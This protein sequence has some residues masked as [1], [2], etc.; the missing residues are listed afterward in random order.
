MIPEEL[1]HVTPGEREPGSISV[2][3]E[4]RLVWPKWVTRD[5]LEKPETRLEAEVGLVWG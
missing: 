1:D 2:D 4:D 5:L 3:V